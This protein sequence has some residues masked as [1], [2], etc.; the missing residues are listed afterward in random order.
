MNA[1]SVGGRFAELTAPSVIP[2]P[3]HLGPTVFCHRIPSA[4][5]KCMLAMHA[6]V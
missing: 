2:N 4:G 3:V 5:E 6:L 1:P